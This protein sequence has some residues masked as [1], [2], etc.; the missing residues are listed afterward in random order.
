MSAITTAPAQV[1]NGKAVHYVRKDA[2]HSHAIGCGR[3]V[4][5]ELTAQ[6]AA[7]RKACGPCK[8]AVE[9]LAAEPP[10]ETKAPAADAAERAPVA[11]AED[12]QAAKVADI[13]RRVRPLDA[14]TVTAVT[15]F[16][17]ELTYYADGTLVVMRVKDTERTGTT[18]GMADGAAP[19][20]TRPCAGTTT[21]PTW[22][23]PTCSTAPTRTP[24]SAARSW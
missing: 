5:R 19:T 1:G 18:F 2:F 7:D 16:D 21:A 11:P 4:S 17:P 14:D 12:D 8:R 22:S 9:V 20:P 10:A 13:E 15:M 6:E 3:L 23:P 24:S